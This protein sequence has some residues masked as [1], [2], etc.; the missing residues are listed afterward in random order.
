ML[1]L[2]LLLLLESWLIHDSTIP[3]LVAGVFVL[4]VSHLRGLIIPEEVEHVRW[5]HCD[6]SPDVRCIYVVHYCQEAISVIY[7]MI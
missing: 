6:D 7:Q 4:L 3:D 2:L 5:F 1:L